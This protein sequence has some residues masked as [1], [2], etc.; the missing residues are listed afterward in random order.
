MSSDAAI[1]GP[2]RPGHGGA[3]SWIRCSIADTFTFVSGH[4]LLCPLSRFTAPKRSGF[5]RLS[6]AP[7]ENRSSRV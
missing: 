4:L 6:R 3:R 2:A 1:F 7:F 5:A